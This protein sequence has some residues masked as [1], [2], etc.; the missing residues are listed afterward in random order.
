MNLNVNN[1]ITLK[2]GFVLNPLISIEVTIYANCTL[3][4]CSDSENK[5][6][7]IPINNRCKITE[8]N[9]KDQITYYQVD[10]CVLL[11]VCVGLH[12]DKYYTVGCNFMN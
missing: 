2:Y 8:F 6:Y 3:T 4:C 5:L 9:H 1:I 10:R 7:C 11:S 12:M